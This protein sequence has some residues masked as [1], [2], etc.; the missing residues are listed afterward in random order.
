MQAETASSEPAAQMLSL[1][2]ACLATQALHAAARLGIADELKAGPRTIADLSKA[3]ETQADALDRLMRMLATLG[4]LKA[5]PGG[6]FGLTALGETLRRDTPNS[7]RDWALYIGAPAPWSAWGHLYGSIKT[8]VPGFVLAHGR[9]TYE[10]LE[11]HPELGAPF[12]RWMNR[13]SAMHNLAIADAYDFTDCRV[14]A[15]IGGGQG[16][17]LAALL[18]RHRSLRGIL[19]DKP[20]VVEKTALEIDRLRD[21]CEV[22][23]GDM[24]SSVP[25]DADLYMIKRVLMI[26]G[27]DEAVR[28]LK[29][30]VARLPPGGKILVVEMVMP[31]VGEPGP[32]TTFDILMLLAN[33]GGRI[34]TEGEFR[35][36]FTAAGLKLERVIRT[37][38][39]NALLEATLAG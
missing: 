10:F 35:A 12:N 5:G 25:A 30:C 26:W 39:P 19:F 7:V 22:I 21:R 29:N 18:D 16:S 24:L 3:L 34:R 28:V 13:Q 31:P 33:K 4:V 1:L 36:L 23:G 9:P 38:S 27:D 37:R 2:N 8:G 32:A 20:S 6:T 14:M 11:S 15:D 17:T